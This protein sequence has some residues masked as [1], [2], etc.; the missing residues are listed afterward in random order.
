M[1]TPQKAETGW[2][3]SLSP[4]PGPKGNNSWFRFGLGS[5]AGQAMCTSICFNLVQ[6]GV[7]GTQHPQA[8]HAW[9]PPAIVGL[10]G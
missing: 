2:C 8:S 10:R 3:R 7:R 1:E 6:Q 4:R 9:Q 5:K